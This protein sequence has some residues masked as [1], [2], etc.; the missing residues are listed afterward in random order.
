MNQ[1]NTTSWWG[2]SQKVYVLKWDCGHCGTDASFADGRCLNCAN[3]FDDQEVNKISDSDFQQV[4]DDEIK[5]KVL[6]MMWWFCSSCSSY[7]RNLTRDDFNSWNINC[8]CDSCGN[9]LN[10]REDNDYILKDWPSAS[11]PAWAVRAMIDRNMRIMTQIQARKVWRALNWERTT[12]TLKKSSPSIS[13]VLASVWKKHR[14]Q[15][16]WVLEEK[17][18][19]WYW[20]AG[21]WATLLAWFL[22]YKGLE[23]KNVVIHVDGFEWSRNIAI[24]SVQRISDSDWVEDIDAGVYQTDAFYDFLERNRYYRETSREYNHNPDYCYT[25]PESEIYTDYRQECTTQTT[26]SQSCT[27]TSWWWVSCSQVPST[28]TSCVSIPETKTRYYD[29][30]YCEYIDFDINNWAHDR[31]LSTSWNNQDNPPPYWHKFEPV[32]NNYDLWSERESWR[33]ETY[34]ITVTYKNWEKTDELELPQN[35]WETLSVTSECSA[36]ASFLLW[37]NIETINWEE[38]D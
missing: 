23:E 19:K 18:P 4:Y 32:W 29:Q 15:L 2:V 36:K 27:A 1:F 14:S 5:Y 38:C 33:R 37:V 25:T 20:W 7:N 9:E 34:T 30:E 26:Y 24:D 35:I 28:S 22:A 17:Y 21:A 13:P 12:K 10:V 16:L 11:T 31:N 8:N 3:P 6:E